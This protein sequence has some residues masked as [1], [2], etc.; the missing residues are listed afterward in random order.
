M[1]YELLIKHTVPHK[2]Q[3]CRPGLGGLKQV[4]RPNWPTLSVLSI[5]DKNNNIFTRCT[6]RN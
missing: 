2:A 5:G 6:N 3:D 4:Y 1:Y